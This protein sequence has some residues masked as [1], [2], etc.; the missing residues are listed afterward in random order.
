MPYVLRLDERGQCILV[1]PKGHLSTSEID[2][3]L[4]EILAL[5]LEKGVE[6]ILCD[7]R[8][9]ESA[10]SL[11]DIYKAAA[12][13]AEGPLRGMRLAIVRATMPQRTHFFETVAVN[14]SAAVRVFDDENRARGWLRE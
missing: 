2:D 13:F 9:L 14:R 6:R 10:P 12:T 11:P 8:G 5:R 1:Y 4:K 3:G 7:Q